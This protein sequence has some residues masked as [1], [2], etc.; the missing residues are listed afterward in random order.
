M[1]LKARGGG[2]GER[3]I[4]RGKLERKGCGIGRGRREKEVL[5]KG[6]AGGGRERLC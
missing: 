4:R 3:R 5:G 6:I 1:T 2:T